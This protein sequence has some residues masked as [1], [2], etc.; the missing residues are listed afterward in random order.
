MATEDAEVLLNELREKILDRINL[1]AHTEEDKMN[2]SDVCL[3]GESATIARL[4]FSVCCV[5]V[6]CIL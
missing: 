2:V 4:M 3:M 1:V 5:D 6:V